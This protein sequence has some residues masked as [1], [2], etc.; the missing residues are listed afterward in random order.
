MKIT[1]TARSRFGVVDYKSQDFGS[2]FTDH[3]V[4]A[5][6]KNGMWGAPE[7]IPYGPMSMDP[8]SSVFHYGQALV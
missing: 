3:M 2:L 6:Y 8:S 1:K 7:I 5:D 4:I